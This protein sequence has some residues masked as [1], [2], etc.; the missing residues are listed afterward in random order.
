MNSPSDSAGEPDRRSDRDDVFRKFARK[1]TKNSHVA[2]KNCWMIL[3]AGGTFALLRSFD[4]F[5]ECKLSAGAAL[6]KLAESL[7]N[8]GNFCHALNQGYCYFAL[9][10]LLFAIYIL[11]FYRFYVG[12]VRVFDIVY[13]EVFEF[14]DSLHEKIQ[15]S[16]AKAR[17][18]NEQENSNS[19]TRK[20]KTKDYVNLLRYSDGLNKWE[21]FCLILTTLIIVYL[22]V[23]PL[24]AP[25]F[26]TVYLILLAADVFWLLL[27]KIPL[28]RARET[29]NARKYV[30]DKVFFRTFAELRKIKF[31]RTFPGYAKS[32]WQWNNIGC[33]VIL[34]PIMGWY[35]YVC[36]C[37]KM[38]FAQDPAQELTGLHL[39]WLGAAVALA[40]CLIDLILARDFYNPKFS[41]AHEEVLTA[42][43]LM[44]S[45]EMLQSSD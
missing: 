22:T 11:A 14:I 25:K 6:N 18:G 33:L 21:S 4:N 29:E 35:W 2:L 3:F 40:N 44:P 45:E 1:A 34:L 41:Q 17:E 5:I 32:V 10:L 20:K 37:C 12:N 31:D 30:R 16:N 19:E 15:I 39:L 23:T 26:L 42:L 43:G 8:D 13:D 7:G 36:L 38:T 9:S 24:N 27:D 28:P